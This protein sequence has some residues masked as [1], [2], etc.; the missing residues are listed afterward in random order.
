MS[1]LCF[2][3]C[4]NKK[5]GKGESAQEL[6]AGSTLKMVLDELARKYGK[7]F[8]DQDPNLVVAS[9]RPRVKGYSRL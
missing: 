7:D 5:A 9:H 6:N 2:T 8:E 4:S 1:R 3:L